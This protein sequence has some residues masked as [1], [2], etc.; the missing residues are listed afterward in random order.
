[1]SAKYSPIA[2]EY[3]RNDYYT[4]GTTMYAMAGSGMIWLNCV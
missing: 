4:P 3:F 1:M 2:R